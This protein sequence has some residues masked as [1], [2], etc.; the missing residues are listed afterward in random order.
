MDRPRRCSNTVYPGPNRREGSAVPETNCTCGVAIITTPGRGRPR[1]FCRTCRPPKD[2]PPR[3]RVEIVCRACGAHFYGTAQR[4]YCSTKCLESQKWSRQTKRRPCS[5]CGGPTGWRIADKRGVGAVCRACQPPRKP[6]PQRQPA[7]VTWDC[8]RCGKS[9]VRPPTKGQVPRYCSDRCQ[10]SAAFD[11]R[12]ARLLGVFVEEVPRH[13]IYAADG[14]RCY[15]CGRKTDPS[16]V[17]PHRR[18]PTID[19]VIPL[20]RGGTHER[21]NCRTA[22]YR[23]NVSKQDRGGG[24]QF[25]LVL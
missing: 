12:R 20:A 14:Y 18:A 10:M 19:H 11:R 4:K 17:V 24:E 2:R 22:C 15:L 16:K 7:V 8:L 6:R 3:P 9:C 25:A 13:E 1:L 23:C 5:K 21:A